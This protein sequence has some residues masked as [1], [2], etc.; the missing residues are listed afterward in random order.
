YVA[1]KYT[2]T[3]NEDD[4]IGF[5]LAKELGHHAVYPVDESGD[6]P[7]KRVANYAKANGLGEKLD[8][9]EASVGAMVKEQDDFLQSHTVLEMFEYMNSDAMAA[10][11]VAFYYAYVPYG[12]P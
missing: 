1:G 8:K 6:F 10:K 9:M 11:D 2:L 5:R 7:W 4:Q 12:D 3:R